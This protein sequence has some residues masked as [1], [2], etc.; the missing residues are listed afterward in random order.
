[1]SQAETAIPLQQVEKLLEK[2]N[3]SNVILSFENCSRGGNNRIYRVETAEGLFALKQYFRGQ[4][5][6]RDRLAS[7]FSFFMYA[8]QVAPDYIPI[9]YAQN[10][11]ESLALYELIEG[12][13][14]TAG[15]ITEREVK[16]AIQFFCLL[17]QSTMKNQAKSLPMASEAGFCLNDHLLSVDRRLQELEQAILK[18]ASKTEA[19]EIIRT[20]SHYWRRLVK[21]YEKIASENNSPIAKPLEN[22]QRCISPSDFGFHNAL[23]LKN[24]RIKFLDF[25]YAGWDDPA[26][27]ANDFFL[28]LA[29]PVP[30]KFYDL[31]IQETMAPF[32]DAD[33]LIQRAKLL[34]AIFLIKWCCIALNIFVPVNMS[35]RKFANPNLNVDELRHMQ[36]A[37]AKILL[38]TLETSHGLY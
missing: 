7:E 34:K 36:I 1:M 21:R 6:K 31:F 3:L 9:P 5:D 12:R 33:Q 38:T 28:Q 14:L 19:Q 24:K 30:E 26:K 37:K 10:I 11:E 25:E 29:V 8:K 15:D 22:S 20:L 4:H 13:P 2:A 23:M 32:P 27:M 16:Q 17:N 18:D 35:R